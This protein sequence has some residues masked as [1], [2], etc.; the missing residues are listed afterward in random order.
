ML[1]Y[2]TKP[3]QN[4]YTETTRLKPQED[5]YVHI[6]VQGFSALGHS[7]IV[8]GHLVLAHAR[9]FLPIPPPCLTFSDH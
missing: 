4:T 5:E 3:I 2:I 1:A 7:L 6:R 9:S 8:L